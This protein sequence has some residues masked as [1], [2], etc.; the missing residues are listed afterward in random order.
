M[1]KKSKRQRKSVHLRF[2][3]GTGGT[4]SISF[5]SA[6]DT[7]GR[8]VSEA[9]RHAAARV[10]RTGDGAR[11]RK[12]VVAHGERAGGRKAQR[13]APLRARE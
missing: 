10:V 5:W 3:V 11:V 2:A 9:Q 6:D 4:W 12:E 1:I 8:G 13:N 7:Q